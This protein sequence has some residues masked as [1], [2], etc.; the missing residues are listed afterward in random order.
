LFE[1]GRAAGKLELL[2]T[3]AKQLAAVFAD[4]QVRSFASH[5]RIATA[6]KKDVLAAKLASRFDPLLLNLIRLLLDKNR[7]T[8]LS[9]ILSWFD[10]LTDQAS[11][12]EGLTILSA[13]ELSPQQRDQI[14][15]L[16]KRFSAYGDL[17]VETK[18]DPGVIGG[19]E[20]RLGDHLVLDGT[21]ASRLSQL[22]DRLYKY[23]HRGL[24][25]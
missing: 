19:V 22:R 15:A 7:I 4:R 23:R 6:N 17:R 8:A 11:G 12:V 13:V 9:D 21:V 14:V 2:D 24:G 3:Q 20:V 10:L 18:I 5:P 25:A 16:A 1:A